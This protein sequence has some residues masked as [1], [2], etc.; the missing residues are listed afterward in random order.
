MNYRDGIYYRA[1]GCKL[2][3]PSVHG[4]FK[5]IFITSFYRNVSPPEV[6]S[7]I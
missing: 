7:I 6:S 4:H 1:D 3:L 2:S 5:G